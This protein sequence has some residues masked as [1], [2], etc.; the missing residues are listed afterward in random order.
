MIVWSGRGILIPLVFLLLAIASYK[1]FEEG[2]YLQYAF[3]FSYFITGGLSWYAGDRWNKEKIL[4][5]TTENKLLLSKN[6]HRLFWIPMQYW[7]MAIVAFGFYRSLSFFPVWLICI[8]VV[9]LTA[10]VF[11]FVK[12]KLTLKK[13]AEE[14]RQKALEAEAQKVMRDE[15]EREQQRIEKEDHSRFMPK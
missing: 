2:I 5:D 11:Y 6:I 1:L 7:G 10:I 8:E 13:E 3:I 4:L 12:N 9:V 14:L 15:K